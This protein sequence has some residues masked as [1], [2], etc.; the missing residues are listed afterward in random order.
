[1]AQTP[2]Y[3][4]TDTRC[5]TLHGKTWTDKDLLCVDGK[6]GI[7]N[8]IFRAAREEALARINERFPTYRPP[9]G[10]PFRESR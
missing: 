2:T 7:D 1:M 10:S 4:R 3:F 5:T 9:Q 6:P 8:A